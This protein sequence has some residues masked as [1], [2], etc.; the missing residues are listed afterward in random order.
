M[1]L[2]S[3]ARRIFEGVQMNPAINNT[4]LVLIP[5]VQN[6]ESIFQ[7][8]PISLCN[9]AHKVLT[10]V[11]ANRLKPLLPDLIGPEQ[12]SFIRVAG[13][14]NA[15][16]VHLILNFSEQIQKA[17]KVSDPSTRKRARIVR[18]IALSHPPSDTVK[19]NSDGSVMINPDSAASGGLIRDQMGNWLVGF[20]ANLGTCSI[21]R[22]EAWGV[23][24]GLRLAWNRGW[25]KVRV[26]VDNQALVS[27]I[28]RSD[29][30]YT[31]DGTILREIKI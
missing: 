10:K 25:R 9:V 31:V 14:N 21:F 17:S 26:E 2:Y 12:N 4:L 24:L 19:L 20:K 6:P 27:T 11:I 5:K 1:D 30:E 23:L 13:S 7:F 15:R 22:A 28:Q 3:V 18:H 16:S 8:R 29:Y